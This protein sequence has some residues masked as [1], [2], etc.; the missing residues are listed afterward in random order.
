MAPNLLRDGQ[1]FRRLLLLMPFAAIAVEAQVPGAPVLQNAFTNPGIA[2]AAN[3]GSGTG[4]S[5]FA[6]AAAY[7]FGG[8]FQLSGAAGAQRANGSTRGAYGGRAAMS[9][10]SFMSDA[11]GI[12]AFAGVGGATSTRINDVVNN[13]A[14]TNVPVGASISYRRGIGTTRGFSVYASPIYRWTRSDSAGTVT[15]GGSLRGAAALDFAFS[16]SLG[17]TVGG[18]FGGGNRGSE[19]SLI[20]VAISFVPGRR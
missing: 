1:M 13:T 18:E 15:S 10:F 3:F 5:L 8:R 20:G 7:G 4:Q 2:V 9:I 17:V 19:G 14:I 12:G 11:V 16:Q 6:A